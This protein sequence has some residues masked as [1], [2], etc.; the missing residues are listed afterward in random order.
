MEQNLDLPI[1]LRRTRRSLGGQSVQKPPT[2]TSTT[3][4]TSTST[5]VTPK[6]VT[7]KRDAPVSQTPKS[8][9]RRVRFSDPGPQTTRDH[10]A[11][12]S[13]GLTPLIKRT[14]L[15]SSSKTPRRRSTPAR[16]CPGS[17]SGSGRGPGPLNPF[18]TPTSPFSGEVRFLPLRQVLDGRVKRRIRRNGLSEEMNTISAEKRRRSEEAKAEVER[19]RAEL[20]EKDQEIERLQDET[21]VLD[22]ERV[23]DLERQVEMLRRELEGRSGGAGGDRTGGSEEEVFTDFDD[24]TYL[25]DGPEEMVSSTPPRRMQMS[26]QTSFPTPPATS[27]EPGKMMSSPQTPSRRLLFDTPRSSLSIEVDPWATEREE[28]EEEL[29]SL[30]LEV[31]KLS[32]S[33]ETYTTLTTRLSNH[34]PHPPTENSSTQEPTEELDLETRLTTVLH[35]LTSQTTTLSELTTSLQTLGF[36]GS[37]AFS[38]LDSLRTAFRTARLELEYLSPGESTLPLTGSGAALLTHLLTQL[39]TLSTQHR[40][41]TDALDEAHASQVSLRQQLSARASAM[42]TLAAELTTAQHDRQRADARVA[43][44]EHRLTRLRTAARAYASEIVDLEQLVHQLEDEI[45]DKSTT[46]TDLDGK[47][48]AAL[49][50]TAALQDEITA[51]TATHQLELADREGE[52]KKLGSE[53]DTAKGALEEMKSV[54]EEL[55]REKDELGAVRARERRGAVEMMG[56]MRGELERVMGIV[57]EGEEVWGGDGGE[58]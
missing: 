22:T 24:D 7:H 43:D 50:Q 35:N 38:I 48:I 15:S 39:R 10:H 9:K 8:R 3:T 6:K 52:T 33:L 17:G 21:V 51:L 26:F 14:T 37:D 42:D 27:P 31:T 53:L 45:E 44:L 2:T 11:S 12:P 58:L 1:A 56:R 5:R 40:A 41:A 47:L 28:L 46:I 25:P 32:A 18:N 16:F 54:V 13:T 20:A 57:R 34:L 55:R 30:R 19:L 29:D 4:S 23:W 49:T 36:P